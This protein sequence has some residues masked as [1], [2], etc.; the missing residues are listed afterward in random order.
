MNSSSTSSTA[1]L[2]P[3]ISFRNRDADCH[4]CDVISCEVPSPPPTTT[5]PAAAPAAQQGQLKSSA[6][7]RQPKLNSGSTAAPQQHPLKSCSHDQTNRSRTHAGDPRSRELGLARTLART[8]LGPTAS[9]MLGTPSPAAVPNI[10]STR[11][12]IHALSVGAC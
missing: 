9:E 5:P 3:A 8:Q 7:Q 1:V 2:S 11:S 12:Q 6:P 4:S 10:H